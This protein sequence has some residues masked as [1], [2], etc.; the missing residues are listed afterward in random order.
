MVIEYWT[1]GI[2]Y[3]T[4]AFQDKLFKKNWLT[5]TRVGGGELTLD[6]GG[7]NEFILLELSFIYIIQI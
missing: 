4:T 5:L 3:L 7:I 2:E 1:I 6:N